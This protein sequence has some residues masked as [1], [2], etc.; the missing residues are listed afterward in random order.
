VHSG[1]A[2]FSSFERTNRIQDTTKRVRVN[3]Q[4]RISPVR[5]IGADGSQ[6]GIMEVDTALRMADEAGLDLVEV[7]PTARP[8]VVRIMD[9]GKYKFEMAKQARIAKKKQHIIE[10]KEVKFRPGI[11]DHDF[12]TKTGHARRFLEEKNKVKVTMMFRG[13]QVAHPELGAAVLDRVATELSDVGKVETSGRL[14]GKLM[15]MILAP[16]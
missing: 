6:L 2:F 7:A 3:R 4:I 16:K 10:L 9:Y 15:T 13:R 11:G 5:V 14:E 8:P 12:A 1:S